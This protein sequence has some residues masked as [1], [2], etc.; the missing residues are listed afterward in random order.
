MD[1]NA[2]ANPPDRLLARREVEHRV[3][4]GRSAIYRL[5]RSGCFPEPVRIGPGTVRWSQREIEEWISS[6][7]RSR[8][9][10]AAA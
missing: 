7:P 6:L 5:M 1:K 3:G 9:Q 4:I 8:G 10:Q 2:G